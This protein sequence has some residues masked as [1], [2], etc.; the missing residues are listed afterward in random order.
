MSWI[1][2]SVLEVIL[3]FTSPTANLCPYQGSVLLDARGRTVWLNTE[4]LIKRSR[5]CVAPQL[6]TLGKGVRVNGYVLVDILVNEQGQVSCAHVVSGP[7]LVMAAGVRAAA[8]WTFRPELQDGNPVSFYGQLRFHFST[9]SIM[10]DANRC[11][12]AH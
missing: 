3:L 4:D 12:E 9:T 5:S 7:V 10:K 8:D 11:T 1:W 2:A 6:P